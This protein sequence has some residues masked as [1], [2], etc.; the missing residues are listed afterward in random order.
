VHVF[1]WLKKLNIYLKRNLQDCEKK[2][3]KKVVLNLLLIKN[4]YGF[5]YQVFKSDK[6]NKKV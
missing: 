3:K 6:K 5:Y 4:I 1:L 2:I